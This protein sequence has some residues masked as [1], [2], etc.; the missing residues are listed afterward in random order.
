MELLVVVTDAVNESA[1]LETFV[2]CTLNVNKIDIAI[3]F[4]KVI[5]QLLLLFLSSHV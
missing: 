3:Y 4:F 5:C 2:W 1:V